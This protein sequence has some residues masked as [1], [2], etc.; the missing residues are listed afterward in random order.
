MEAPLEEVASEHFPQS[1]HHAGTEAQA[2]HHTET[3]LQWCQPE[4][5]G[6][7]LRKLVLQLELGP[8]IPL[9]VNQ[10]STPARDY[11]QLVLWV[12][13]TAVSIL[14]RR[15]RPDGVLHR[16]QDR[17]P[18][19]EGHGRGGHPGHRVPPPHRQVGA[20]GTLPLAGCCWVPSLGGEIGG[21]VGTGEN[22]EVWRMNFDG[23]WSSERWRCGSS[24][25]PMGWFCC[26]GYGGSGDMRGSGPKPGSWHTPSSP[27]TAQ[28]RTDLLPL[29]RSSSRITTQTAADLHFEQPSSAAEPRH[30]LGSPGAV[31]GAPRQGG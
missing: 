11:I 6:A 20:R 19:A 22:K 27:D 10:G 30:P 24:R 29:K 2:G 12:L 23:N 7:S 16:H 21:S 17:V 13:S 31:S 3:P 25:V 15:H 9:G 8:Q 26:Q 4:S 5:G 18:A 28:N 14:Q 1:L